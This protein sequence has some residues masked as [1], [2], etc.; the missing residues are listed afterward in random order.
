MHPKVFL[1]VFIVALIVISSCVNGK[2]TVVILESPNGTGFTADFKDW[3]DNNKCELTLDAG[4][5]LQI[6][7][8]LGSG[9]I[10]L[11][12]CGKSGSV[13]YTGNLLESGLF[14]VG[15]SETD[16]YEIKLNGKNAT[17]KIAVKIVDKE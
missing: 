3:G 6:E 16:R 9:Q 17:G 12:I 11:E 2:G 7:L 1:P 4:D 15:V 14:T 13:P 5:I 8:E 10:D